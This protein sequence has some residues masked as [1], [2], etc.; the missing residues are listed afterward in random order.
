MADAKFVTDAIGLDAHSAARTVLRS[1]ADRLIC[2]RVNGTL[3]TSGGWEGLRMKI[4][5][6]LLAAS[7]I[8]ATLQQARAVSFVDVIPDSERDHFYGFEN[9]PA[10]GSFG[11]VASGDNILVTQ[12]NGDPDDTWTTFN[13]YG[14]MEGARAWYPNG[15]DYG[16]TSIKLVDGA[17]M[18]AIGMLLS[19]GKGDDGLPS[20]FS[21]R[22]EGVEQSGGTFTN[23][24]TYSYVGFTGRFDE[25]WLRTTARVPGVFGDGL[26]NS[27]A[28]DSIEV[29]RVP[30]PVPS[31]MLCAALLS[32][33]GAAM[34]R[35]VPLSAETGR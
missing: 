19:N 14:G 18:N 1:C 25:I 13:N 26:R 8:L 11:T 24:V 23:P 16:F 2:I 12:V 31:L 30:L 10:T 3:V 9:L 17:R 27:L 15:G 22:L 29:S 34:R 21:L 7:A 33:A 6:A 28:V 4:S 35:P 32:L 5:V 20:L